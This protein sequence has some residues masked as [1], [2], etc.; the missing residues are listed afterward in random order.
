MK[1]TVIVALGGNLFVSD[2][3]PDA[4]LL[5]TVL[6]MQGLATRKLQTAAEAVDSALVSAP[7]LVLIDA[8]FQLVEQRSQRV[9]SIVPRMVMLRR[10]VRSP[11]PHCW[12]AGR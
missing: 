5:S 7:D 12:T 1:K 3:T 10:D 6:D 11:A 9:M 8:R 4:L 2:A